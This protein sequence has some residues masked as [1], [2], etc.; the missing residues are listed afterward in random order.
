MT[1]DPDRNRALHGFWRHAEP[2][3]P[4]ELTAVAHALVA[5]A[6]FHDP[7]RLVAPGAALVVRHA[8]EL[9]LLLHPANP[10]AEDDAAGRQM[11]ERRQHL[12]GE[13]RMAMRQDEHRRAEPD[14]L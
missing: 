4:H 1:A 13:H 14:A 12:G 6:G 7:D 8:E 11:I 2:L 3:E 9:D 5:P 10:G